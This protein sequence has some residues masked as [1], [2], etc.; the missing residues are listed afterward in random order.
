VDIWL[1][2]ATITLHRRIICIL[3]VQSRLEGLIDALLDVASRGW[4]AAIGSGS[5]A[6]IHAP[7]PVPVGLHADDDS[8]RT[9]S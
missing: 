2:L 7:N 8:S 5:F 3:F 6:Q 4:A 9:F 1:G